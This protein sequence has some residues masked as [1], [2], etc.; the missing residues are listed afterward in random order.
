MQKIN[1]G[2]ALKIIFKVN[3]SNNIY[4]IW[5]GWFEIELGKIFFEDILLKWFFDRIF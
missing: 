4:I 2:K 5:T 1:Y 3:F